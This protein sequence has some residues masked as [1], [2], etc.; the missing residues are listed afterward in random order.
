MNTIFLTCNKGYKWF[1]KANEIWAKGYVFSPDNQLFRGEDLLNYFAE[2]TTFAEFQQRAGQAN[3]LFSAIVRRGQSVWAAIDAS[4][5]FPLF[6][7]HD[8]EKF[9]LTDTPDEMQKIGVPMEL[10][11][12]SEVL[13]RYSGFITG[14]KT[15]LKNLFQLI[16]GQS[17]CFENNTL[18]TEFH[19]EFLTDTFFTETREELK[20]RLEKILDHVGKRMIQVLNGRPAGISLSG[21]F[22]SRLIAYLLKRNNY[23]NVFCYT[24]GK[25][26][27][28]EVNNA[29]RTAENLGYPIYFIDYD[30]KTQQSLA[31][32]PLFREYA[33]YAGQYTMRFIEQ[34][35]SALQDLL[36]ANKIPENS[37]FISGNSGAV[38]GHLLSPVMKSPDYPFVEQSIYS[39]FGF[40][41]PRRKDIQLIRQNIQFLDVP[42]PRFPS[43]LVYENWRFQ[44]TTAMAF[45]SSK[46]WDFFGFEYLFPLWDKELFDFFV[47]V[48]FQHKYDKNLYKETLTELFQEYGIYFEDEELYPSNELVKKVAFRT[49]L[50]KQFPFLK[51]FINIWK[52]DIL[53]SKEYA[54]GFL[55][56]LKTAKVRIKPLSFNGISS[57]WYILQVKQK[58]QKIHETNH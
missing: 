37:V 38:A 25:N 32:N 10:D 34:D 3:G 33:L 58:L 4:R 31:H 45:N 24:Y 6:Y 55:Q 1:N 15:L 52:N 57:A 27:N 44:G 9:L 40:V 36:Q 23:P 50:K 18:T 56:D 29:R 51:Q 48:P 14:K 20:I 7:Y 12:E 28:I 17:L 5:T 22:D 2:A 16:A 35:F 41:Y 19:T 43:Y 42:H 13:L 49:K 26:N 54:E 46:I 8:N 39:I 11:G 30:T 47:Q 21:G 53:G